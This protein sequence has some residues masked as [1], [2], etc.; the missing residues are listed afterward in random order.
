MDNSVA[1]QS[2]DFV[3]A[4]Y[5]ECS[6]ALAATVRSCLAQP[7]VGQVVVV[8]DGS[9]RPLGLVID[10]PRV[11]CVRLETNSGISVARN[12]GI[13]ATTSAYV[14]CVNSEIELE[15]DWLEATYRVLDDHSSCGAAF[16]PMVLRNSQK[17]WADWRTAYHELAL[18]P[19]DGPT[20]C[21][22]GHAVLFRRSALE[23]VGGYDR[24]WRRCHED[25]DL[26][27]R[28]SKAGWSTRLTR[29]STCISS[30]VDG[31]L[32]LGRK[33]AVR[34]LRCSDDSLPRHVAC[35]RVL[36][37]GA[38]RFGSSIIHQR[39]SAVVAEPFIMAIAFW[40]AVKIGTRRRT[41][42][43]APSQF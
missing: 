15:P 26:C 8:D 35:W 24:R 17:R 38:L 5:N 11:K 37:R 42:P 7:R 13:A 28:L 22:P 1:W 29:R 14:A 12:A 3:I 32:L 43:A 4:T 2:V 9:Q 18:P 30:Q 33:E 6:H 23:Q 39:W 25:V 34:A 27:V 20:K 10:D 36:R 21:A 40:E 19:T 16:T 41:D 31:P